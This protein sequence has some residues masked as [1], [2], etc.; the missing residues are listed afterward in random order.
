MTSGD[1]RP[2]PLDSTL[3]TALYAGRLVPEKDLGLLLKIV[4]RLDTEGRARLLFNPEKP[5]GV[6]GH[7]NLKRLTTRRS[8]LRALAYGW[9]G[10]TLAFVARR[11]GAAGLPPDSRLNWDTPIAR[12]SSN[13]RRYRADAQV[14]LLGLPLLRRTGVGGGS[15]LWRESPAP[16]GGRLR[17]LE[18]TGFSLPER[19][20]GLNRMG[21]I[22]ELARF[23]DNSDQG[24][25]ESIYFGLM[26]S[27][28][29][30]SA[31]E[32]RRA[33]V[34]H[35]SEVAYSAIEG[36]IAADAVETAGA[37]FMAPARW[38]VDN[39]GELVDRARDAL[40]G[41]SKAATEAG[42]HSIG[43][44]PFLQSL[45]E[46]LRDSRLEETRYTYNS[47]T[48]HMWVSRAADPK[49]TT[50]FRGHGLIGENRVVIRV[51][52]K[53]R[54]ETGGKDTNFRLWFEPGA[55]MPIPLRIEYQAKSYLRL[56]FEA[57]A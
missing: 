28:P 10:A 22:R 25:A 47:R 3:F 37:H 24:V 21:F 29:E 35:A 26:T 6:R 42:A 32:A 23:D 43:S 36:R 2:P 1:N 48:Y 39:R 40:A 9:G 13:Q 57:E 30:E 49:A 16:E 55:E 52:G 27:S 51:A 33:M 12:D 20:A 7:M 44:Q 17:F 38:S 5:R 50:Y 18:F 19:A 4:E 53:I 41:A 31:E 54:R 8:C 46:V 14:L 11:L 56:V 34:S 15:A 45:A